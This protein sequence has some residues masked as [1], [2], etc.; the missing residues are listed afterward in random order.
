MPSRNLDEWLEWQ[1][2]I[3]PAE[4]ELGLERIGAVWKRLHPESF[5]PFLITVGGT[6]GKGSCVAYLEAMLMAA[7]WRVGCYTSPHLVRYNERIRVDGKEI[8]DLTLCKAFERIEAA[9]GDIP[10]TYFEFG[11]LAA[12]DIFSNLELDVAVL[13]VGLGGRLDA[14]NLLDADAALV[15]S[16]GLDHQQWL[17]DD[18]DKI[19]REKAGILR[20]GQPS[21]FGEPD[22]PHGFIEAAGEIGANVHYC[23]RDYRYRFEEN[24]W[25]WQSGSSHRS[26]LPLPAL[27]GKHQVQNAAAVMTLL[28]LVQE[29][30]PVSVQAI[31]EGLHNVSVQGR[32]QVVN[33]SPTLIF[34]VAHNREAAKSLAA[35]LGAMPPF[36]RF[37]AVF[38]MFSD[39]PVEEVVAQLDRFIDVWH[40]YALPEPRGIEVQELRRRIDSGGIRGTVSGYDNLKQALAGAGEGLGE[41]DAVLVFGSFEV[42]GEAL[43]LLEID[44][45]IAGFEPNSV[46]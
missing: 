10:L 23:G 4:I 24:G 36:K 35:N 12:L 5:K 29:R 40:I 18:L 44:S 34:D 32:F 30:L 45:E 16:I 25:S 31:K 9:R 26:G 7:S 1:Q 39:K 14:S 37:N 42:V 33:G 21:V 6:N 43:A 8:D 27:R 19:G 38:S 41:S 46:E 11:T 15:T 17:G 20:P 22:P 3:H 28:A 2:Q 13:E